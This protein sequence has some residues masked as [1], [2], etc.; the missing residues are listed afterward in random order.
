MDVKY[1]QYAG[2]AI[3]LAKQYGSSECGIV[4]V[5]GDGTTH[6]VIYG[7]MQKGVLNQTPLAILSQGTMNFFAVTAGLPSAKELPG[8]IASSTIRTS[9]IMKVSDDKN[10]INDM[11]FEAFHLGPMAYNVCKGLAS[12]RFL[13]GGTLL[14]IFL[15]LI[16]CNAFPNRFHL[17]GE[18]K[19]YPQDGNSPITLKGE[20]FW[21]IVTYRNPYNGCVGTDMWVSIMTMDNLPSFGRRMDFFAPP[22][23]H[24]CGT[25]TSFE[26]HFKCKKVVYTNHAQNETGIVM[27]GDSH[28][29]GK[30][31]TVEDSPAAWKV[32]APLKYLDRLPD[33]YY[34]KLE[35]T[36]AAERWRAMR[37]APSGAFDVYRDFVSKLPATSND[38]NQGGGKK[39]AIGLAV[40]VVLFFIAKR[41]QL[42]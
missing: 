11:S 6:E 29:A 19:I 9:S 33:K 26:A 14:G 4:C 40:I 39:I 7:L 32:V 38:D 34:K 18:L 17:E 20:F 30:V 27:D 3:E 28:L 36:R 41:R 8:L 37:P 21:I 25:S 15:Y 24:F 35:L 5:G 22:M 16:G 13:P 42:I 10:T 12:F 1:T 31:V 2:H 23:E